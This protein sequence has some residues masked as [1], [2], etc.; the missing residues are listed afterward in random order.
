VINENIVPM[1]KQRKQPRK[2]QLPEEEC[3]PLAPNHVPVM[4]PSC[5]L[6]LLLTPQEAATAL[7]INR[8]TLYELLMRGESPSITIGRA[9]RIPVQALTEWIAQQLAA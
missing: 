2:H 5:P 9:R 4:Q 3:E 6:K 1:K 7:S 8:S